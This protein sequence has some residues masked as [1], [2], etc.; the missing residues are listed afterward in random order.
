MEVWADVWP[1]VEFFLDYC[2]TQW[3]VGGAGATG[4]DHTA[5]IADIKTLRLPRAKAGELYAD[6]RVMERAALAQMRKDKS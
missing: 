2:S 3:R 6:V 4:L 1:A 5:V